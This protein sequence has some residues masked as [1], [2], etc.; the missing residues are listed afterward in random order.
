MKGK[1]LRA[2]LQIGVHL[3]A[4]GWKALFKEVYEEQTDIAMLIN[5]QKIR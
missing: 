2:L 1:K 3:T 4:K 5:G